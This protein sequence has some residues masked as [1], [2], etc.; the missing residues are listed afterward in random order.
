MKLAFDY[1]DAIVGIIIGLLVLGLSGKYFSLTMNKLIYVIG[2]AIFIVFIILDVLYEFT[3]WS[4]SM[5]ITFL[6]VIHNIIDGI[7][8]VAFISKF[9][10]YSVPFITQYL[11]PLLE[12][13][14]NL[15]YIAAFLIIGNALW[16]VTAPFQG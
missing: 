10:G 7:I 11:V 16:L 8:S 6:L 13:P 5:I 12:S 3:Q 15:F 2:F 9:T 1:E 14:A 4:C